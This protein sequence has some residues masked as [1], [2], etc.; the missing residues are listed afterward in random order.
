MVLKASIHWFLFCLFA[1]SHLK[2]QSCHRLSQTATAQIP[3][4][5]FKTEMRRRRGALPS[6]SHLTRPPAKTRSTLTLT[7]A[8]VQNYLLQPMVPR[9]LTPDLRRQFMNAGVYAH[10]SYDLRSA[11]AL[12]RVPN[13]LSRFLH[14]PKKNK[15][16]NSWEVRC[17]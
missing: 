15:V 6:Q 11:G 9:S 16:Y 3:Y 13:H 1:S 5:N 7:E 17:I 2:E 10:T 14:Q 4:P 8:R 12:P